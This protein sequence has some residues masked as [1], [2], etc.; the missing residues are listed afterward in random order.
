MDL[1]SRINAAW[2]IPRILQSAKS[3]NNTVFKMHFK[4]RATNSEVQILKQYLQQWVGMNDFQQK[5][6]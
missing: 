5:N 1:D 4:Q 3:N 2:D 6:V